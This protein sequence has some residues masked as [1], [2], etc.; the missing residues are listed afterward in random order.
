MSKREVRIAS[1]L[2]FDTEL[3]RDIIENIEKL[4]EKR[5]LT[6]L[7]E[8][9]I[10]VY[11]DEPGKLRDRDLY[12]TLLETQR[13]GV[14]PSRQKF[15]DSVNDKLDDMNRKI[16]A[17]EEENNK[18]LT[19]IK[20]GEKYG[21]DEKV[22]NLAASTFLVNKQLR[23]LEKELG[24]S[25]YDIMF[26]SDKQSE[27]EQKAEDTL[28]FIL[29]NYR[30]VIESLDFSDRVLRTNDIKQEEKEEAEY[31]KTEGIQE[32]EE[33]TKEDEPKQEEQLVVE[34]LVK[35]EETVTEETKPTV[36]ET[37]QE[38]RVEVP[39]TTSVNTELEILKMQL[40]I[41]R[42][43]AEKA[44]AELEALKYGKSISNEP[45]KKVDSKAVVKKE[46]STN[47]Q[48]SVNFENADFAA[49]ANFFGM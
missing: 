11:F 41:E 46:E 17:L 7:I 5:K 39:N 43:Q 35:E 1:K 38:E 40:E 3:E 21:V 22:K 23:T 47:T 25:R 48:D 2:S 18:M 26:L 31:N 33:P 24:V 9:L 8:S 20:L 42:L 14:I 12:N 4:T 13:V 32:V 19:L 15:F 34:Q 27:F 36:V 49:M 37:K 45:E 6:G 28:E 10:R 16:K 29:E 44:K 30:G